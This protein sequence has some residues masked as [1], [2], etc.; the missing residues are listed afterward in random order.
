MRAAAL[1]YAQRGWHVL[2]LA[3]RGKVPAGAGRGVLDASADPDTIRAWWRRWPAAN[4]GIAAGAS[5]LLIIDLDGTTGADSYGYLLR[6]LGPPGPSMPPWLIDGAGVVTGRGYHLYFAAPAGVEL[7]PRAG[8]R[9]GFD[10]RAG[11]SYVVGP[12]SIHPSGRPYRWLDNQPPAEVPVLA[13]AWV[14]FL[15][16]KPAEAP[17]VRVAPVRDEVHGTPYGRAAVAG[18][19]RE[20]AG[21][22]RGQRNRSTYAAARRVLDLHRDGHLPDPDSALSAVAGCA[23]ETGLDDDETTTTLASA[24]AGAWGGSTDE[25]RPRA[26]ALVGRMEAA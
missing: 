21:S 15:I 3:A 10:V 17:P 7:R 2:P 1:G 11:A 19:L 22:T 9:P 5:G 24:L 8:V 20:L 26:R 23:I 18:V 6:E 4:V 16:D 25:H 14:E 12:P 13:P